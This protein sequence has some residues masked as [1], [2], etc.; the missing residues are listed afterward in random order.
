MPCYFVDN[1]EIVL[2]NSLVTF[3]VY[4]TIYKVRLLRLAILQING[5]G[6]CLNRMS[7][8]DARKHCSPHQFSTKKKYELRNVSK[9][10]HD[11]IIIQHLYKNSKYL[12]LFQ[13]DF[14]RNFIMQWIL[15]NLSTQTDITFFG[16][17]S[18]TCTLV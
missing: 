14:S 6:L 7:F 15:I 11:K 3:L 4:S 10:G 12:N 9:W 16:Y 8:L 1:Y 17:I 13:G 5:M 18:D 2:L